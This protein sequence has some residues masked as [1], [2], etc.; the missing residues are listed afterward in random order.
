[1]AATTA[2][3]GQ[4]KMEFKQVD[5]DVNEIAPDAPEGEWMMSIPR[6]KCKVQPTKEEKLP[7]LIVPVRLDSTEEEGDKF[8]KALGN[9]LSA[10][11]TFGSSNPRGDRLMKLRLRQLCEAADVELDVIPRGS[12]KDPIAD[13]TPLMRALEGKKFKGWTK[14][15]VR[16]DTGEEVTDLLFRD[17]KAP[18]AAKSDDDDDDDEPAPARGKAAKKSARG[19]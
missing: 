3:N 1:M 12:M 16:K 19:R 18:L 15:S 4:K 14:V 5:F 6:G 7:L 9:E 13:L 11:F 17:P 10:M 2:G 8:Q